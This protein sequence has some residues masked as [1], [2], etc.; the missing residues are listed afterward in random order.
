MSLRGPSA[1]TPSAKPTVFAFASGTYTRSMMPSTR[2]SAS[3]FPSQPIGFTSCSYLG[4]A[5]VQGAGGDPA[6]V[7]QVAEHL[8]ELLAGLRSAATATA[9]GSMRLRFVTVLGAMPN[10][11]HAWAA[12]GKDPR[13]TAVLRRLSMP[14]SGAWFCTF[15][16][17]LRAVS[18]DAASS[19]T[20]MSFTDE[21]RL[22][23]KGELGLP[24]SR[25]EVDPHSCELLDHLAPRSLLVVTASTHERTRT[26][27]NLSLAFSSIAQRAAR[28]DRPVGRDRRALKW[29]SISG[30][31]VPAGILS[32]SP[33]QD[34]RLSSVT[35][36]CHGH[37]AAAHASAAA[38][39]L[40]AG[41]ARPAGTPP[42]DAWPEAERGAQWAGARPG[43]AASA[44]EVLQWHTAFLDGRRAAA[45]GAAQ[46][47]AQARQAAAG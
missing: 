41:G 7:A 18:F 15:S 33:D 31:K 46:A 43:A 30:C 3:E 2:S 16:L 1:V 21:S 6:Q 4:L 11:L 42:A 28:A 10:T 12:R 40:G 17:I 5:G 20:S 8:V 23:R 44:S 37:A 38:A 35:I 32:R 36:N 19:A 47:Q 34:G 13:C 26:S 27:W 9:A 45:A 39:G 24:R 25:C 29:L 14:R 22:A